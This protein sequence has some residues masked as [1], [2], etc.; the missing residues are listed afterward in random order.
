M[1][2][3]RETNNDRCLNPGGSEEISTGEVSNIMGDL[4][5]TLCTSSPSMDNT[6]WDPLPLKVGK[7]LNQM[8]VLK[9]NWTCQIQNRNT[10]PN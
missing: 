1:D 9:E 8:I 7:F 2:N 6:F 3:S 4:K 10:I 5:E